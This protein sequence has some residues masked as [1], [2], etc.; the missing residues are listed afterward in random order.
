MES[1]FELVT[2]CK[3][4]QALLIYKS[5]LVIEIRQIIKDKSLNQIQVAKLIECSQSRI[6]NLLNGKIH[7]FSL[8]Y[9]FV[10]KHKLETRIEG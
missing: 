9:L 2:S 3:S 6:S 8:D 1:A 5:N 10:F 7:L 4:E